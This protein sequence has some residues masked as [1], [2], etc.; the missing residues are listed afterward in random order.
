MEIYSVGK[1]NIGGCKGW[2]RGPGVRISHLGDLSTK[3]GKNDLCVCAST[4][5]FSTLYNIS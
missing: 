3:R 4:R 1:L 2:G 5:H